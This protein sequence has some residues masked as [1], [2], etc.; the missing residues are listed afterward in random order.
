MKMMLQ[1]LIIIKLV[2]NNYKQNIKLKGGRGG[3]ETWKI[4]LGFSVET[5]REGGYGNRFF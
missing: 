3:R 5:K 1:Q 2:N 4:S